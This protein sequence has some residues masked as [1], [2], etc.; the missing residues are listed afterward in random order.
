MR[1][2]LR[3]QNGRTDTARMDDVP[4]LQELEPRRH[5]RVLD[6]QQPDSIFPFRIR[7]WLRNQI[8]RVGTRVPWRGLLLPIQ[9]LVDVHCH[10]VRAHTAEIWVPLS[11]CT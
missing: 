8:P 5:D 3:A 9:P 6:D 1:R 11:W 7:G 4:T 2:R 10:I